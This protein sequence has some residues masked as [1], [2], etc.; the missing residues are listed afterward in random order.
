MKLGDRISF[1]A[2]LEPDST[3]PSAGDEGTI[4]NEESWAR[5]RYVKVTKLEGQDISVEAEVIELVN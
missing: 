2:E 1:V 3:I 4:D 5:I